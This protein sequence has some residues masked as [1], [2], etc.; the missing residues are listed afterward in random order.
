MHIYA[1]A[2]THTKTHIIRMRTLLYTSYIFYFCFFALSSPT[3]QI[4]T[5]ANAYVISVGLAGHI[6]YE[7]STET[8]NSDARAL[9]SFCI[10]SAMFSIYPSCGGLMNNSFCFA[11]TRTRAHYIRVYI[12]M[13]R[14]TAA[15]D[16]G[17]LYK[18]MPTSF[19]P[20]PSKEELLVVS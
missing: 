18:Y 8:F 4:I 20:R 7:L 9:P 1:H 12:M 10:E 15:S 13:I 11:N 2:H 6:R 14:S 3:L 16:I 5:Y 17:K 19:F